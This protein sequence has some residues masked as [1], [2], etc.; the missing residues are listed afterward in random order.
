MDATKFSVE[1]TAV[2]KP[3]ANGAD[4]LA[5]RSARAKC[6]SR[7]ERGELPF[8]RAHAEMSPLPSD[9]GVLELEIDL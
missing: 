7:S 3:V 5:T 9:Q 6:A 2:Q 1:T 8:G 4:P